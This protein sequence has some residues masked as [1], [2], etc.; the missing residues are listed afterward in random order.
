MFGFLSISFKLSLPDACY[1]LCSDIER[2][3]NPVAVFRQAL[4]HSLQSKITGTLWLEHQQGLGEP[5]PT[6]HRLWG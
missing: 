4:V 1:M 3:T 2:K 6:V 5:L